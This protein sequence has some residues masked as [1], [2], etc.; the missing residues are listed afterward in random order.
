MRRR[1]SKSPAKYYRSDEIG[2]RIR[3]PRIPVVCGVGHELK[4]LGFVEFATDDDE[5]L[6]ATFHTTSGEVLNRF[7]PHAERV[8]M[9]HDELVES[10]R[11]PS[12]W[13]K[14]TEFKCSCGKSWCVLD[15]KYRQAVISLY[16]ASVGTID[17]A[18]LPNVLR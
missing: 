7:I 12:R 5:V 13:G 16:R 10:M 4:K 15:S 18:A 17:I 1:S 6:H 11:D 8:K 2:E 3:R 9:T 14:R